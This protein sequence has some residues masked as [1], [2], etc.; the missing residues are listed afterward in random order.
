MD[1]ITFCR[2]PRIPSK[3]KNFPTS[4][5]MIIPNQCFKKVNKTSGCGYGLNNP[6]NLL[7][8]DSKRH[9]TVCVYNQLN[10]AHRVR[11]DI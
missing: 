6:L 11:N 3:D 7:W 8:D 5:Q 1:I 2:T 10:M 4:M 9:N